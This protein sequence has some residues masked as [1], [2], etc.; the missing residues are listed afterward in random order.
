[1]LEH[2]PD[3]CSLLKRV[4]R[5]FNRY[6]SSQ[7]RRAEGPHADV[8]PWLLDQAADWEVAATANVMGD[9]PYTRVSAGAFGWV[10]GVGAVSGCSGWVQ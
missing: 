10:Q 2:S 7:P 5:D 6:A 1:M 4:E 9:T 3:L 8:L